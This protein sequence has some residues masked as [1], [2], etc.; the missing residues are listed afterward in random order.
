MLHILTNLKKHFTSDPFY[1]W[2]IMILMAT[3]PIATLFY[4]PEWLDTAIS[5]ALTYCCACLFTLLFS[6]MGCIGTIMKYLSLMLVASYDILVIICFTMF[7]TNIDATIIETLLVTNI[8]EIKEFLCVFIP[9]WLIICFVLF[10]TI[11]FYIYHRCHYQRHITMGNRQSTFH[12]YLLVYVV[13]VLLIGHRV[14]IKKIQ[15]MESW[16]IP[17]ENV[18]INLKEYEPQQVLLSETREQHPE[19]IVLI[20]GESH[21][22][23]HSSI[24]G[25]DKPTNPHIQQLINDSLLYAFNQVTSP[26]TGTVQSF[27]FIL[28]TRH[29][30]DILTDWYL[31][32]SII[33]ILKS[34]GYHT[35]WYSNQDE[36]GLHDN[37]ASSFAHICDHYYFNTKK[38]RLDGD[39]IGLHK[40]TKGK[41]FI[42]YHLMGQHVD[43]SKR[44]PES[45]RFF[46]SSNYDKA[47]YTNQE[48]VA[49]YD[50]ACLYNDYVVSQ[51]MNTYKNEDAIVIYFPDHGLD[52]FQT[53]SKYFGH[54]INHK[55]ESRKIGLQIPCFVYTSPRF[56]SSH[57]SLTEQIKNSVERKYCT[58]EMPFTLMHVAG[59]DFAQH[60]TDT[61]YSLIK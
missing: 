34:A 16:T 26:A 4:Q 24:Y 6:A 12:L 10:L 15:N 51:L 47:K 23:G 36:V 53:S 61:L 35:S 22:K 56:K 38:T 21:S 48:V 43:F 41:E 3:N 33:T 1:L 31:F 55:K 60:P 20:I 7:K 58:A 5:L 45:F 9:W 50:N 42:I 52:V 46:K 39:L 59:Y 19:K 57:K 40:L 32:P 49:H 14:L 28:N 18:A 11:L 27:K 54:A 2:S 30:K 13:T 44:Y 8:N 17:F 29:I 25:Y 37:L